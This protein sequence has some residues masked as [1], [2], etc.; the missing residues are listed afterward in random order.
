MKACYISCLFK[1]MLSLTQ[2][3]ITKKD[4]GRVVN[5]LS[6][7]FNQIEYKAAYFTTILLSPLTFL[8]FSAILVYR[9]GN[10]AY[11]C[12]GITALYFPI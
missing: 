9:L 10:Y 6:N 7:D 1:K 4:I 8:A 3:T 11:I 12:I 5:M 2:Y